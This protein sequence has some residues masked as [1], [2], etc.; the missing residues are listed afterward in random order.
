MHA[1]NPSHRTAI[2][3]TGMHR[4]GAAAV[5]RSLGALGAALPASGPEPGA[6]TELNDEL[7]SASGSWWAGWQHVDSGRIPSRQGW[8]ER[9]R[10]VVREEYADAPLVVLGD[11]R[12]SRLLPIWVEAL[13]AEG[14]RC[15]HVVTV[16]DPS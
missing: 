3:V 2:C 4:S 5:A 12:M 10:S 8:V 15:V 14:L 13:R 7:L 1:E 9:I 16:R 6:C 11:P